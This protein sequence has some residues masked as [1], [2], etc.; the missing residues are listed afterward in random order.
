MES[1]AERERS[2][3]S[4]VPHW[5]DG[6]TQR[7]SWVSNPIISAG[8]HQTL[9]CNPVN[10]QQTCLININGAQVEASR[11]VVAT[12]EHHAQQ[13]SC[14]VNKQ[15]HTHML[16]SAH[17][18]P[19]PN[20][21]FSSATT[22]QFKH[23]WHFRWENELLASWAHTFLRTG[24]SHIAPNQSAFFSIW[25]ASPTSRQQAKQDIWQLLRGFSII[26]DLLRNKLQL[27]GCL[28]SLHW[29]K[30]CRIKLH[31]NTWDRQANSGRW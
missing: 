4:P 6:E 27:L 5:L 2:D 14:S 16:Q 7:Q 13:A 9:H 28:R 23:A 1:T 11:K 3:S 29:H 17:N 22:S 20:K 10:M 31:D 24:D 8:C 26:N 15:T 12:R 30:R 19:Q 25:S 18:A 21:Y